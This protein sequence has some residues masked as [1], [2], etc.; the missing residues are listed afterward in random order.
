M[1]REEKSSIIKHKSISWQVVS[2]PTQ[3]ILE[4]LQKKHRFHD[5]DIED[6]LSTIQRPKIDEYDK[7]LFIVLQVPEFKGRGERREVVTREVLLF[8]GKSYLI[9]L[10][11]DNKTIEKIMENVNT[12]MK[13]KK[14]Y[15]TNG[16]G[17]LL[18]MIVDDL[19]EACFPILDDL[20][21][22]VDELEKEVFNMD[23]TRDRLKDILI[24]KNDLI[25]FRR[26]IMP[27]R[28]VIAQ[29]EHKN[30]K[31]I[32]ED[33]DVY[34]DDIVDKIEKIWNNIGNL[35]ELANS[36]HETNESIIS[37]NTNKVIKTLTILSVI[38]LPLTFITG[39][40]GMNISHLPYAEAKE[41]LIFIVGLLVSVIVVMIGYFKY[42][43]WM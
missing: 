1:H 11:N 37:H 10:H 16:T 41:S 12:K 42:K 14:E 29:L 38:M 40:Y 28:A 8:I 17:Y 22:Q 3:D 23:Y 36:I 7:Y 5:L 34:F 20:S 6:C 25:N 32:P 4:K 15:M 43:K 26:I 31:F 39:F 35:Q 30:K 24:L 19:F 33:L 27:Q 9:T 18:Y 13:T 2:N 21:E